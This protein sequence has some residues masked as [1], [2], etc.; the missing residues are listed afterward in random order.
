VTV[1]KMVVWV[2]TWV[3]IPCKLL[4]LFQH[5]K[6][7][8]RFRWVLKLPE[9]ICHP[10]DGGSTFLWETLC[11][12]LFLDTFELRGHLLTQCVA[13]PW[14]C[15]AAIPHVSLWIGE[16]KLSYCH[17]PNLFCYKPILSLAIH[18]WHSGN[19]GI[20]LCVCVCVCLLNNDFVILLL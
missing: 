10:P 3:I 16:M 7:T 18:Y 6:G 13:M 12:H 20:Y 9:P 8:K 4:M 19:S 15:A 14:Q 2:I 11:T 5:C 17:I 1:T